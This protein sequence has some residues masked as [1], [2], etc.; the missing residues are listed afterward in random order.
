MTQPKAPAAAGDL[1]GLPYALAAYCLWGVTP[2]FFK[3]MEEVAP[4]EVLAQRIVWSLP[5]CVL[6]MYFRRQIGEYM[7]A[8]RDWRTLRLLLISATLIAANWLVYIYAVFTDHVL[9]A[10]LGY[11]LNPLI[12]VVLGVAV[13]GERLSRLQ[14]LAVAVA[15]VGVIILLAGAL[16]TLWISLILACSFGV[17]GLLR[18]IVSVGALPGLAVET[19]LLMPAAMIVALWF[20]W[21]DDGWGFGSAPG[22]SLILMS[23]SVVTAVPLLLFATAARRMSYATLGFT[24]YLAPSILFLLSVFVFDEP[25]NQAQLVCFL[26]IWTSVAIFSFDLWRKSRAQR[27]TP[28]P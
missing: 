7:G 10:S 16:D 1:Q 8:F 12:N 2:F 26:L 11:Y 17:Y 15:A 28:T 13:L 21:A 27:V 3:L 9:A 25:L 18:K 14:G 24:Q 4:F 6:I 23:A 20:L 22:I 5:F 19:T